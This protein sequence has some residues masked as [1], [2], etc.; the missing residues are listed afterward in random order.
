[1]ILAAVYSEGT[2]SV[3]KEIKL[4]QEPLIASEN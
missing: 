2:G 3:V 1:M 4:C